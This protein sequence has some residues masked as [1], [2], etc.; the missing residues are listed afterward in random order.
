M[1][2]GRAG[3]S[4]EWAAGLGYAVWSDDLGR[5]R[6]LLQAG[7]LADDTGSDKTPL[8][9]AVDELEAFYDA[10]RA[11]MTVLLLERG[12]DPN[13]R[14]AAG[15]SAV[16]YAAGAGAW[17]IALLS[18]GGAD[19][20]VVANDGKTPLHEAAS[21]ECI[22]AV[23]ALCDR[24]ADMDAVDQSGQTPRALLRAAEALTD[25]E[26]IVVRALLATDESG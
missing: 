12:A 6:E 9:E 23:S 25:D 19:V 15:C 3:G 24:G 7:T 26:R 22:S 18:A 14:D 5:V 1:G 13:R 16:H 21:R 17:A 11:A 10:D 4:T 8:M 2:D 20:N